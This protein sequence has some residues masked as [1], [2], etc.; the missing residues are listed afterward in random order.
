MEE[1]G[2]ASMLAVKRS[3]GDAPEVNLGPVPSA[4]KAANSG[5]EAQRRRH[6]KSKTWISVAS[7]K[8]LVSSEI[9]V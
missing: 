9:F 4:N 5:F 2:S 6:Q 1:N 7:Q 8:G 3:A